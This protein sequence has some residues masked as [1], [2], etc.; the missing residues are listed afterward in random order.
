MPDKNLSIKELY[1][2]IRKM[3]FY[4][5]PERWEAIYLYASVIQRDNNEEAGEM[6]FYYLPK[7][8]IKKNPVNV[9]QIPLKFNI[10]EQAYMELAGKL[11]ELIKELRHKCKI[12]HRL[13]WTNIT[14]SIKNIDFTAEY[15]CDDLVNSYYSNVDRI[16]IWQYMYLNFPIERFN[17]EQREVIKK[18]VNEVNQGLHKNIKY[19][20]KC[21]ERHE[22]NNIQY[23]IA[24][25]A[26]EPEYIKT[27]SKAFEIVSNEQYQIY[28]KKKRPQLKLHLFDKTEGSYNGKKKDNKTITQEDN[29]DNITVRNQILRF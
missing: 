29:D 28:G 8:I 10:E 5:I 13:N 21:Y 6:F 20:E 15:N 25:S 26:K 4:M 17:K 16:A 22:H 27:D 3:L 18:Y 2:E 23:D 9:Y 14:I 19:E 24:K 7:G 11:Y 12:L 1:S